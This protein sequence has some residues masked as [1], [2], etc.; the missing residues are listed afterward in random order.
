MNNTDY[1]LILNDLAS[2]TS[3]HLTVTAE[4]L[5]RLEAQ[6]RGGSDGAA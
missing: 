2:A 6:A 5:S 3:K 4:R 1:I